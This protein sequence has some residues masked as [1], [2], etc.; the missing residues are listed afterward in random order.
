[1]GQKYK[2]KASLLICIWKILIFLLWKHILGPYRVFWNE[3]LIWGGNM[4]VAAVVQKIPLGGIFCN[5][6]TIDLNRM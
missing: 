1:M 5:D 6:R 3:R 4:G 2:Q